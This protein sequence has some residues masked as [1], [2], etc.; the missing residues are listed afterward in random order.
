[1]RKFWIKMNILYERSLLVL[2]VLILLVVLYSMY[3]MYWVFEHAGNNDLLKFKPNT[4]GYN[5]AASPI[6]EE[7]VAWLTVDNTNIDYPVMQAENN[8][9]FLNTDPYGQYS[10]SGSIF[11]DSRNNKE[12]TDDYIILYGHHM[13]YGKM[14]G[15]LDEFLDEKYLATHSSGSLI[16]GRDGHKTYQLKVFAAM[17]TNAR[18]DTIFDPASGKGILGYIKANSS[19][20]TGEQPNRILAMSTCNDADSVARVIVFAY[21][22]E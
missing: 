3:D 20:F 9:K 17:R 10:L 4:Q 5:A 1:M 19:V 21:I 12:M 2:F 8:T 22:L 6:T 18:D 16:V 7:M 15:A 13:E 11:A 14:F